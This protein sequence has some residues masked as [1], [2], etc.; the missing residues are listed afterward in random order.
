MV[1]LSNWIYPNRIGWLGFFTVL[2]NERH[3]NRLA[4]SYHQEFLIPWAVYQLLNQ[5]R[6]AIDFFKTQIKGL[7]RFLCILAKMLNFIMPG[8]DERQSPGIL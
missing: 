7:R 8:I 1:A 5:L 3:F 2:Q 4:G 6:R